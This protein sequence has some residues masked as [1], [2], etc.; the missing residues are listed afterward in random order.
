MLD[1][2]LARTKRL[3][4]NPSA[5]TSLYADADLK[6]YI[7]QG[8]GQAA[9][10]GEC[11]TNQATLALISGQ[12]VYNFSSILLGS[13]DAGVSGVI[14]VR[15]AAIVIGDGQQWIRPRGY[16]WFFLY[17]LNNIVPE[18]GIP[19]EWSVVGQ[20]AAPQAGFQAAGGTIFVD[21]VP[22]DSY[23]MNIDTV[24]YPIPLVDD[25]TAEALPYLFTDA[26]P[27]FAAYLALMSAQTGSR[28]AEAVRMFQKYQE[29]MNRARSFSTP[30]VLGSMYRQQPSP[31]RANQL[32][33]M[34]SGGGG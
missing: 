15:Q 9:G 30:S 11:I 32:G 20:G 23:T 5:P 13:P 10:E 18:Q 24:C 7:N 17:R 27:Y 29:F 8:R 6:D 26:I 19:T 28:E 2:Y 12:R 22:D 1:T 14:N 3:L 31:V 21:P 34:P 25:S 33:V 16:E 4:Q